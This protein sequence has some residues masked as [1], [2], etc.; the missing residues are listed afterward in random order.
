MRSIF[1]HEGWATSKKLTI[2]NVNSAPFNSLQRFSAEYE[3]QC[4]QFTNQA[5]FTDLF[6]INS[7]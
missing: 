3:L 6:S 2:I 5:L 4:V 7:F 1:V